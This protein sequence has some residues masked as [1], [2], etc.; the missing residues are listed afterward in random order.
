MQFMFVVN[1]SKS[2]AERKT[3]SKKR[4]DLSNRQCIYELKSDSEMVMSSRTG[5]RENSLSS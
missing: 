4:W 5:S 2:F 3:E 1:A